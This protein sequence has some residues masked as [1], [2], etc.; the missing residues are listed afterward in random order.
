MFTGIIEEKGLVL[1]LKRD[2]ASEELGPDKIGW[3]LVVQST[4]GITTEGVTLGDSIAVNGVCLTVTHYDA[5][6]KAFTFGCAPETMRRTNLGQ[7]KAGSE[8][9]LER[10]LHV[11]IPGRDRFG[12]H[13]V[14]GHVDGTGVIESMTPD[15]E[16]LVIKI[17]VDPNMMRYIVEKGYICIDGTSLTVCD[18]GED[19]FTIMMIAFTQS[20]VILAKKR[21]GDTVNLELDILAKYV[22]K[23]ALGKV[24]TKTVV[25]SVWKASGD[26]IKNTNKSRM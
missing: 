16:S 4:T 22:E 18:V 5:S 24:D 17:K 8:V 12:G 2:V 7:L 1:V 14:E 11:S 20:K 9:N 15:G 25:Q 19:F 23:V 26:N 21:P 3:I 10:A 13:F 6:K